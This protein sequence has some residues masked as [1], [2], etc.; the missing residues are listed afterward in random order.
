M[1][2]ID[3]HSKPAQFRDTETGSFLI[4]ILGTSV[5]CGELAMVLGDD[6]RKGMILPCQK[7][8]TKS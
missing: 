1:K 7:A 3:S 8:S 2:S 5:V 6:L 4:Y